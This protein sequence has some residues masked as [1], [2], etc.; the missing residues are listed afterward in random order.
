MHVGGGL[1]GGGDGALGRVLVT[2]VHTLR[3]ILIKIMIDID[4]NDNN[5]HKLL[6]Q[7]YL[8]DA[9]TRV[10]GGHA[11]PGPTPEPVRLLSMK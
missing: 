4:N 5:D 9:I 7:F 8:G 6:S 10:V 1:D 2:G 11:L 3:M